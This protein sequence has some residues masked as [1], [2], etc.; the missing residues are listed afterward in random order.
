MGARSGH[1]AGSAPAAACPACQS[2]V[3]PRP[4]AHAAPAGP[5]LTGRR[6]CCWR[7]GSPPGS[8]ARCGWPGR[9]PA[10]ESVR[11]LGRRGER[12]Q[13]RGSGRRQLGPSGPPSVVAGPLAA[14]ALA[15]PCPPPAACLGVRETRV[16]R[17]KR[18]PALHRQLRLDLV[19]ALAGDQRGGA[20]QG[21]QEALPGVP[22]A[23]GGESKG[24]SVMGSRTSAG[25]QP[26]VGVLNFRANVGQKVEA[27]WLA[28]ATN[29]QEP[30]NSRL[31]GAGRG[32][33]V[34]GWRVAGVVGGV[35]VSICTCRSNK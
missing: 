24:H 21:L 20:Q 14:L 19:V 11:R 30:C 18:G 34:G 17:R 28:H 4:H 1:S 25:G 3:V 35:V 33:G 26:G 6:G 23:V 31:V 29:S 32:A 10:G 7:P 13:R 27:A 2:G 22:A 9:R 16:G 15:A 12:R 8:W 5:A